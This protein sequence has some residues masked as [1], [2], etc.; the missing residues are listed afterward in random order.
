MDRFI[1]GYFSPTAIPDHIWKISGIAELGREMFTALVVW[2]GF[3]TLSRSVGAALAAH[4]HP[5]AR[6]RGQEEGAVGRVR[7]SR[8]RPTR[9][10]GRNAR[11]RAWRRSPFFAI[12]TWI[13]V[14][15]VFLLSCKSSGM[16][17]W[18]GCRREPR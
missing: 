9:S 16:I 18:S 4:V 12:P 17:I 13:G 14:L 1:L 5:P 15:F 11:S 8:L 3:G 2:G 6:R 7:G 10:A